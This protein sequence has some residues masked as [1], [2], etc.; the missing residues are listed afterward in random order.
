MILLLIVSALAHVPTPAQSALRKGDCTAFQLTIGDASSPVAQMARARCGQSAAL[1]EVAQS[2]SLL[3][4][5][6]RLAQAQSISDSKPG[7]VARLLE[8]LEFPGQAGQEAQLLRG[9]ALVALGKSLEARPILRRL[10][11]GKHGPEARYW[12]SKG[13]VDRGDLSAAISTYESLWSRYPASP[14]ADKAVNRL[15]ELGQTPSMDTAA[16]QALHLLRARTLL[17]MNRPTVAVAL[18]EALFEK[19]VLAGNSDRL[20][21]AMSK[22]WARDYAGAIAIWEEFDPINTNSLDPKAFFHYALSISRTGDYAQAA[23]A[24]KALS[25]RFPDTRR[26]DLASFKIGYLDYDAGRLPKA[27]A[28]FRAHLGRRPQSRHADE[29]RWFIG[30]SHYRLGNFSKATEGFQRLIAKHPNSGLAIGGRYWLTRAQAAQGKTEAAQAG[31]QDLLRR[32]PHSG[33]A[34]FAAQRLGLNPTPPQSEPVARPVI[35]S[36]SPLSEAALLIESG[37]MAWARDALSE[38]REAMKQAGTAKRLEYAH[39]LLS[40]GDYRRSRRFLSNACRVQSA[41]LS[42]STREICLPRPESAVVTETAANSGLDPFLPY[43]IMTAESALDPSVTSPAGARG[44]M[45]LMPFLGEELHGILLPTSPYDSER[46]YLPGYNAWFGTTELGRLY[47]RFK[48][49]EAVPLP[50]AIA[51]YNGGFEAVERWL[52]AQADAPPHLQGP[53]AFM[54]N[55]GYTE[56]RRYVRKVLGYLMHYHAVYGALSPDVQR[57]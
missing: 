19:G 43:A 44:L 32:H 29:A 5:W 51:G 20:E 40:A 36:D 54:E 2:D 11:E 21:F 56:T 28:H 50:M 37:W 16:G 49:V 4:K 24:Y 55:I 7:Q 17:K 12:L 18:F 46:L 1:Q 52:A 31:L 13:A 27:I 8:G 45:Q 10:L 34:Y 23:T 47:T 6:A 38:H 39:L 14:W 22:F 41:L 42:P 25:Q 48:A 53:D 57:P 35:A 15:Q 30:W 9:R 33:Y 26:G 3:S